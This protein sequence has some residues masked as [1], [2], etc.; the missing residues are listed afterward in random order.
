MKFTILLEPYDANTAFF[1]N[2]KRYKLHYDFAV[3]CLDPFL[4][5]SWQEFY[6]QTIGSDNPK[7]VLGTVLYPPTKGN[8]PVAEF[9]EYGIQFVTYDRDQIVRFFSIVR[10]AVIAPDGA[11]PIF[12]PTFEQQAQALTDRQWFESKGIKIG[13]ISRWAKGNTCYSQGWALG[14]LRFYHSDQI[15]QAYLSGELLSD[16][17]LLTDGVP[18]EIPVLAGVM[19]L[20]PSTPNSHVAILSRTYGLPFVYLAFQKDAD[21]AH[22]LVGH[23]VILTAYEDGS[24]TSQ[25][26]L[27]D[28]EGLLDDAMVQ[29]ILALKQ[30]QP[31]EIQP[32]Q[33]YGSYVVSVEGLLPSDARYVGGKA[34]NFGLL[35]LAI[36]NNSPRALAL[37]F[38]LWNRFLDQQL[39]QV[40]RVDLPPGGHILLW[41]DAD[42]EQGP[43]HMGFKLNASGELVALFDSDGKT[44]LDLVQFGPQLPDRSFARLIDGGDQWGIIAKP[45]P[46]YA[47]SNQN[48]VKTGGLVINELMADNRS[49]IEDPCEA[50]EFPDWIELFNAS[51]HTITLNGLYLTD[52]LNEPTKWQIPPEVVGPTLREEIGRRLEDLRTYPPSDLRTLSGQLATIRGLF[53]NT[54]ITSF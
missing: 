1:Q 2:S 52:D 48:S 44:L 31:L 14:R 17:I 43:T 11:E 36:P 6:N 34:A 27:I 47:N 3:N 4:G 46:G 7:A 12:M 40:P 41:A 33:T 19:T 24:G 26:R 16:D 9:N 30:V 5:L 49:T 35:R 42:P 8:P 38:D 39:P 22:S 23:R 51:D 18:A 25:T 45:T 29:Q 32:F 15:Y 13:S 53:A 10:A 28:V 20:T 37:T 21:L 50:G 54:Q